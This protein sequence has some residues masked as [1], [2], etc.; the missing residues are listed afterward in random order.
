MAANRP[1]LDHV[2]IAVHALKDAPPLLV[3]VLGGQPRF[4]LRTPAFNFGQWEF[5]GG[6]R[7]EVL[8]PAGPP[9]GFLH[10]FVAQHGPGI[11]HVTFTVASLDAACARAESRGYRIVGRDDADPGWREAFLH[12]KEAQGIVVQLAESSG[13]DIERGPWRWAPPAP[14]SP[15]PPATIV[16]VRLVAR[17]AA[18]AR[19]Q[20]GAVL[21]GHAEQRGGVLVFR[22]PNSPLR[23]A[24]EIDASAEEGARFIE[25]AS[26]R[27]LALPRGAQHDLGTEF[28]RL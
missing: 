9:D 4:G 5:A 2:A 14:P 12:P 1:A 21:Q 11:H 15:P 22:W 26:D 17:D 8:E 25:V 23:I 6:G 10:R 19:L 7:L 27:P 20:W 24:V 16:G 28:R 18:R 13:P 3:G